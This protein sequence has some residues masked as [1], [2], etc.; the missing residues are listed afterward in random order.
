VN[1][2]VIIGINLELFLIFLIAI[3]ILMS[4]FEAITVSRC[5]GKATIGRVLM[6]GVRGGFGRVFGSGMN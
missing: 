4:F 5:F 2:F 6:G 3:C 1:D